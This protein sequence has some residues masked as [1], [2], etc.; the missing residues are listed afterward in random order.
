MAAHMAPHLAAHQSVLAAKLQATR[1]ANA[2]LFVDIE[3]QRAEAKA[4][5]AALDRALADVEAA[6]GLLS[7]HGDG[8][9]LGRESKEVDAEMAVSL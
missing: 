9:D 8:D 2:A 1:D 3:A 5:L 4:L 6:N 7:T